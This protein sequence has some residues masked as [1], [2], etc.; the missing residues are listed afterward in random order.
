MSEST[1]R[2][3]TPQSD[4]TDVTEPSELTARIEVLREENQRLREE[5]ARARRTQYRRTALAL[6]VVGAIAALGGVFFPDARTVLFALGGT[7]LF[8]A[9]LTRYLTPE[10]FISATVGEG[11]YGSLARTEAALVTE[12]GL[13][14]DRLY[15][16]GPDTAEGTSIR[17]FVPQR[18]DYELPQPSALDSVFVLT[19]DE[20]E[21]GVAFHPS[22]GPLFE[23]FQRTLSGE[24]SDEPETLAT[25]LGDGLVEQFELARSAT[26]EFHGEGGR[27]TVAID[28][29][30]YGAIDRIDHPVASFLGVGFAVGLERA[31]SVEITTADDDRADSLVTCSWED[32]TS[33][34][35]D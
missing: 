19:D 24:L 14:D 34:V 25:Q 7:G 16:P 13:Q 10:Q 2:E 23:E 22:G 8:A 3:R 20:D 12:L 4:G 15:L 32:P 17:L 35:F 31:V 21:R 29:S 6:A 27:V 9:A 28:G 5:Y 11:I 26:P 18:T 30:A 33:F 1:T